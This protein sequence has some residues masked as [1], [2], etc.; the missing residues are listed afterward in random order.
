MPKVG[1]AGHRA[2]LSCGSL[3]AP[4]ARALSKEVAALAKDFTRSAKGLVLSS[5]KLTSWRDALAALPTSRRGAIIDE[6]TALSA[7]FKRVGGA[8][9]LE[10]RAQLAALTAVLLTQGQKLKA[11]SGWKTA[12]QK[13]SATRR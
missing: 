5:A 4:A 3:M 6:L 11:A 9:T 1:G 8:K 13:P 2:L 10:A 7:K 12:P